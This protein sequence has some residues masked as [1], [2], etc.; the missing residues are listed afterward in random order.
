[1][2]SDD[3]F[4]R[5]R[6]ITVRYPGHLALDDVD[7]DLHRGEVHSLMGENGAGKSTLIKVLTGAIRPA[8][9]QI[10]CNGAEVR[11]TS[12]RDAL[13]TGIGV[14][15]QETGLLPNLSVAENVMLG[16]EPHGRFGIDGRAMIRR[17]SELL[18]RLGAVVDPRSPLGGHPP[19]IRQ[20]VAMARAIRS[21]PRVLVLDEPT[22]SLDEAETEHV[23]D[24][25]RSLRDEDVAVLFVSHILE[26]VY[27]I[28]DR[29]T[30]LRG[31]ILVGEFPTADIL[32]RDLVQRM[33]GRDPRELDEII[34][35]RAAEAIASPAPILQAEGV[36]T[37]A[38]RAPVDLE[39]SEGEIVG[40]AGLLGSGR[41]E[42]ARA[43]TGIDPIAGGQLV[44]GTSTTT[45]RSP[46]TAL[47]ARVVYASEN[48][49]SEGLIGQ[50]S[51]RENITLAIQA[52]RGW[53][54]RMPRARQDELAMSYLEAL[55]VWPCDP[56]QP[57]AS[58][59]S[60][61]QQKVLLAR[62]LAIA[63]RVL[64]LDEPTR[65]I[66]V[67]AKVEVQR[68]VAS[69]AANG[70]GVVYIS[71]E[72]D[73]VLRLSDRIVIMRDRSILGIVANDDELDRELLLTLIA[74][75]DEANG[76]D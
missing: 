4:I 37:S 39:V 72:P 14:V 59:S 22:A 67:G 29:L 18:D 25:I 43:I 35:Q 52:Q 69:M 33:L 27:E 73:E 75:G 38:L 32:R 5:M 48:R 68:L 54:L 70:V 21:N 11:I 56:G 74:D 7:L 42:L 19:A 16:D 44:G 62:W 64:V 61:N 47:G 23:L 76:A 17:A 71:A 50:L 60:G 40:V 2:N 57:A 6:G 20:L 65:G 15:H 34:E 51:V 49:I 55:N 46:R 8:R 13:A 53:F 63:P 3:P 41:T 24:V 36:R 12:P 9:G 66:D 58:L 31:G 26:Q 45:Y 1:M 10:L 28:A 30:V